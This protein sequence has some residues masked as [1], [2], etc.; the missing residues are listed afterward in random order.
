MVL[1]SYP[2]DF[3]LNGDGKEQRRIRVELSKAWGSKQVVFLP[4][5]R[6]VLVGIPIAR[7]QAEKER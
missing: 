5:F 6:A 2:K 3:S 7:H 4:G 1:C